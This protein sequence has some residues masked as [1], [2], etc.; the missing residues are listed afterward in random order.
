MLLGCL[1]VLCNSCLHVL[2]HVPDLG[3][4]FRFT[5]CQSTAGWGS[6]RLTR[7]RAEGMTAVA[8]ARSA[9]VRTIGSPTVANNSQLQPPNFYTLPPTMLR[10]ALAV[11]QSGSQEVV[12]RTEQQAHSQTP[13][14]AIHP[15]R[16]QYISSHS[17]NQPPTLLR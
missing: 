7:R 15:P 10:S 3:A 1:H 13:Q 5:L 9:T 17:K 11:Q 8:A 12:R 4:D 14:S 16:G 6:I 2:H